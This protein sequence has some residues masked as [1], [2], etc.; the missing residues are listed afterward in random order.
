MFVNCTHDLKE[1]LLWGKVRKRERIKEY[2]IKSS[3]VQAEAESLHHHIWSGFM[4][5]TVMYR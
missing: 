4:T 5:I 1:V 2:S 3:L